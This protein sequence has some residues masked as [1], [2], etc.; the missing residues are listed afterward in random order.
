M[1]REE[2]TTLGK[3]KHL[4]RGSELSAQFL[5]FHGREEARDCV[6][7]CIQWFNPSCCIMKPWLNSEHF[8]TGEYIHV[9][10]EKTDAPWLQG[11]RNSHV[12]NPS[13]LVQCTFM[14]LFIW[15]LYN[16]KVNVSIVVL[17]W[18]LWVILVNYWTE[19]VWEVLNL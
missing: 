2:L 18:I 19:G 11:D 6:Q 3:T 17:S 4:I 8:L 12:R 15:F 9:Y 5:H 16:K 10:R 14:Q 7:S 13:S 1:S